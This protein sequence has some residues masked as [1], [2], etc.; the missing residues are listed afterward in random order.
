MAF[1]F[2]SSLFFHSLPLL[3]PPLSESP[4]TPPFAG[5]SLPRF[6][7]KGRGPDVTASPLAEL[8]SRIIT[9]GPLYCGAGRGAYYVPAPL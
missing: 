1:Y 8:L 7:V 3:D 6:H 5:F 4:I 9:E 2:D